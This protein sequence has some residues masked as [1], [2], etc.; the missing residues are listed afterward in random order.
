MHSSPH[1][2]PPLLA[3][4]AVGRTTV[5]P[6]GVVQPGPQLGDLRVHAGQVRLGRTVF[7]KESFL[8]HTDWS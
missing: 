6:Y 1:S 8:E 5:R 2:T 7:T 4:G 3:A